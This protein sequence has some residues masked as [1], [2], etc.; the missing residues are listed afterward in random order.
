[1]QTKK[2]RFIFQLTMFFAS[3]FTI[4]KAQTNNGLSASDL[5]SIVSKCIELPALQ[6][7][8]P[9]DANGNLN[10]INIV[11]Y[12]FAFPAD[13]AVTKSG[14]SVKFISNE[15]FTKSPVDNYFMFRRIQQSGSTVNL[16]GNY[17]YTS[18]GAKLSKSIIIAYINNAGTWTISNSTIN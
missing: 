14:K 10:P 18:N 6:T 11:N 9:L 13:V 5:S 2:V 7:A 4:A 15:T 12:P 8:Y 1:M 16:V 3:F 17:F